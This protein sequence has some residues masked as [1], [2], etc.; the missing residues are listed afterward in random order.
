MRYGKVRLGLVRLKKVRLN[1]KKSGLV[2]LLPAQ[3]GLMVLT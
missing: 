2:G 3:R 1:W